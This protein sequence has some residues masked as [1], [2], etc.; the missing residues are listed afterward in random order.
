MALERFL[1]GRIAQIRVGDDRVRATD[2]LSHLLQ[3][4]CFRDRVARPQRRLHVDHF[5]HVGKSR[6]RLKCSRVIDQRLD[7]VDV[8]QLRMDELGL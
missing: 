1:C 8:A 3:P 6:L 4:E 2:A 7:G 5:G